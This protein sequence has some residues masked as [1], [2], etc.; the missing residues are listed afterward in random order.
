M[1]AQFLLESP[2]LGRVLLNWHSLVSKF[3]DG[4][5]A[6]CVGSNRLALTLV[7]LLLCVQPHTQALLWAVCIGRENNL[8]KHAHKYFGFFA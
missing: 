8:V 7:G 6:F 2:L 1:F 5:L 4:D 3:F